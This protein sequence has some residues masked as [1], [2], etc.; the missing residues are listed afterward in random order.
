M[1][2]FEIANILSLNNGDRFYSKTDKAKKTYC[3]IK[4]EGK[5]FKINSDQAD[6][7]K[8]VERCMVYAVEVKRPIDVVF[9]RSTELPCSQ[10][11]MF[12]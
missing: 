12:N 5:T 9:L 1:K 3:L 11:S 4:S 8:T 2:K 7:L 6:R 10:I